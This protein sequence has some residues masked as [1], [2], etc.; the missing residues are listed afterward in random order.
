[1]VRKPASLHAAIRLETLTLAIND[2][3]G[4]SARTHQGSLLANL[5]GGT[6]FDP[7]IRCCIRCS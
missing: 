2:A 1:M 3:V 7:A 6:H 4:C 5:L